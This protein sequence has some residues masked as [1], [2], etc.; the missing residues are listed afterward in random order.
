MG[1]MQAEAYAD[2]VADRLL[3]LDQ[4]LDAHLTSNC[5]PPI[6]VLFIPPCK[7]AIEACRDEVPELELELP[8]GRVLSAE[9]IVDQ[10]HL[11]AF[12]QTRPEGYHN[13][14]E[15]KRTTAK[16]EE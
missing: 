14:K 3:T 13:G 15:D 6:N 9:E 4:A 1:H 12:V 8:N 5:Y 10:L 16:R 11:H 7:E 2:A